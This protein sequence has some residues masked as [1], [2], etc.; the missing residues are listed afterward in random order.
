[1]SSS[2]TK[3]KSEFTSPQSASEETSTGPNVVLLDLC[4]R[5]EKLR[6]DIWADFAGCTLGD[7]I[8]LWE[9]DALD[10]DA[11][12][13]KLAEI[14]AKDER[15]DWRKLSEDDLAAG[16][17]ALNF[18]DAAGFRFLLPAF[19][20]NELNSAGMTLIYLS[21]TREDYRG[22]PSI[23]NY[24]QVKCV[25]DF[26]ETFLSDS[27]ESFHHEDITNSLAVFWRPL[28]VSKTPVS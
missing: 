3:H 23:L 18:T 11:D 20:L 24:H 1:M 13:E 17:V 28:L 4:H 27:S 7:G 5:W 14:R 8:G 26:L 10:D 16:Y 19:M 2:P 22:K 25:V 9:A 21:Q 6:L 12:D 15:E